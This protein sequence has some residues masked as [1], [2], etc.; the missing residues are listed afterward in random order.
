PQG[1]AER[2]PALHIIGREFDGLG[3]FAGADAADA[4][5][6]ILEGFHD[7]IE[8]AILFAQQISRG[9]ANVLKAI[10]A[11]SEQSQPC[12]SSFV[13]EIPGVVRSTMN[14]EMP[15]LPLAAGSVRAATIK[16]SP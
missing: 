13:T 1:A 14:N 3:G 5:A 4:D 11:V 15:R 10:S 16:M 8:A 6:F 2:L 9:D 12:L 7:A